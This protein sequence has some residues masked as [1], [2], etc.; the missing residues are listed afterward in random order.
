MHSPLMVVR[1]VF[2]VLTGKGEVQK[3][4]QVLPPAPCGKQNVRQSISPVLAFCPR[5]MGRC[6]PVVLKEEPAVREQKQDLRGQDEPW[7]AGR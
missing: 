3:W 1:I 2:V 5:P 4:E 6:R 7:T